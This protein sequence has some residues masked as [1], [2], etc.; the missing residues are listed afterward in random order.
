[1]QHVNFDKKT[2]RWS[3]DKLH[4]SLIVSSWGQNK[5]MKIHGRRDFIGKEIIENDLDKIQIAPIEASTIE[6]STRFHYNEQT[7][8]YL[9]QHTIDI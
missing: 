6:I 2:D 9:S 1:M 3:V 8:M 5:L 7:G 4:M